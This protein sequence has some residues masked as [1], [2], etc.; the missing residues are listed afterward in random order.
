MI[1]V[2]FIALFLLYVGVLLF[3]A[4][5]LS[6]HVPTLVADP[7]NFGAWIWLIIAVSSII[8]MGAASSKSSN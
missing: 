3:D 1:A 7:S 5:L 4:Y 2:V 6:V 8:A